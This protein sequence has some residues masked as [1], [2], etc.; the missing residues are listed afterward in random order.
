[1]PSSV[2]RLDISLPATIRRTNKAHSRARPELAS[3]LLGLAWL[4]AERA[5]GRP[6]ERA[7]VRSHTHLVM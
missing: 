4:H 6:S 1:M 7:F 2:I 3:F 5:S